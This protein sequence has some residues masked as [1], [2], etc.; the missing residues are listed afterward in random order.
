VEVLIEDQ[1]PCFDPRRV[2][3]PKLPSRKPGGLGI[4]LV[5]TLMDEVHHESLKPQGNRLQLVKY[6]VKKE[7]N[8]KR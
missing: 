6:K 5:R 8:L 7:R 3:P 1:G 4:Y 2:P